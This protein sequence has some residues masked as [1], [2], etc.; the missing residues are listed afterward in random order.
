[1][2]KFYL[3]FIAMM[4]SL[5]AGAAN[6]YLVGGFNG[7]K[8]AEANYKFTDKGDGTYELKYN[9]TF[10]GEFKIMGQS[11]SEADFGG[12]KNMAA[13]ITYNLSG[14]DNMSLNAAVENPVFT[15]N[16]G[17]KTIKYVAESKAELEYVYCLAGMFASAG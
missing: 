15:L 7:W 3:L 1:M 13:G 12:S 5:A 11:W 6:Y 14:K 10:A 2:K 8:S 9:G 4:V 17:A 16:P